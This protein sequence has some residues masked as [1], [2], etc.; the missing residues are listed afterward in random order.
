MFQ[1]CNSKNKLLLGKLPIVIDHATLRE[2]QTR[3]YYQFLITVGMRFISIELLSYGRRYRGNKLCQGQGTMAVILVVL[4]KTPCMYLDSPVPY[5]LLTTIITIYML[6]SICMV[7]V[8]YYYTSCSHTCGLSE[9]RM[10]VLYLLFTTIITLYVLNINCM[11]L[12]SAWSHTCN[13][14]Q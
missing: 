7:L 4:E 9:V 3:C 12:V 11:V 14:L 2:K 13:F 5:L 10:P 8:Y 6:N 1:T